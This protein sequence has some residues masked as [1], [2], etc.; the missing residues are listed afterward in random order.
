[1]PEEKDGSFSLDDSVLFTED[2]LQK[3]KRLRKEG[4]PEDAQKIIDD[5]LKSVR[6]ED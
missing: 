6:N 1:M 3:I 5:I 2:V 4:K